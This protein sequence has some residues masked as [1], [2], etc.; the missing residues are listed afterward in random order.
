M[1]KI[2]QRYCQ[3]VMG[4]KDNFP[5]KVSHCLSVFYHINALPF[6]LFAFILL[7]LSSCAKMGQQMVDGMMRHL[8]ECWV[9]PLLNEQPT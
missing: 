3:E 8:Q 1:K 6:F 9:P 2:K 4:G 7:V 5:T